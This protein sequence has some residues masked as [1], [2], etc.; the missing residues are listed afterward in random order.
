MLLKRAMIKRTGWLLVGLLVASQGWAQ[1]DNKPRKLYYRYVNEQGVRVIEHSIP[2]AYAQKGYEVVTLGGEVVRVVE[3]AISSEAAEQQKLAREE[4]E[5]LAA[6]DTELKR[7][8]SSVR[9]VEAA[10]QRK[11]NELNGNI[12]ILDSNISSLKSQIAQ[13]HANAAESERQGR[14][15]PQA[16]VDALAGLEEELVLTEELL[17]ERQKQYRQV[18]DKYDRDRERFRVI[19]P[20]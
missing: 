9:D 16:V 18:S 7:R 6:W 13:Q 4:A 19:R 20:D 11:L 5:K 3:P 14:K 15:I 10:K 2:P 8:Y 1:K 12:A 17:R